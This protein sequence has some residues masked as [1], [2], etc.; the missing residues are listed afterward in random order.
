MRHLE[1]KLAGSSKRSC[2]TGGRV[3]GWIVSDVSQNFVTD[4]EELSQ[5]KSDAVEVGRAQLDESKYNSTYNSSKNS[6]GNLSELQSACL[7]W[8]LVYYICQLAIQ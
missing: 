8:Q 7:V 3:A 6:V 4:A 1:L 2:L 5:R